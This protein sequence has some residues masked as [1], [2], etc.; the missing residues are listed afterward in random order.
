MY[1]L[2]KQNIYL[3]SFFSEDR[4]GYCILERR[5]KI[6]DLQFP[7]F[8]QCSWN[9]NIWLITIRQ[10]LSPGYGQVMPMSFVP[11][12][13]FL[14]RNSTFLLFDMYLELCVCLCI[15]VNNS[16]WYPDVCCRHRVYSVFTKGQEG[17]N[18]A[19]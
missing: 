15:C 10:K 1:S 6:I 17:E 5:L 12:R 4:I 7:L 18:L 11:L 9:E 13:A 14:Y 16:S 2:R 8:F 19:F 3:V